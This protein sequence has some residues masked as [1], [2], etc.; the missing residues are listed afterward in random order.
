M[1]IIRFLSPYNDWYIHYSLIVYLC[2]N[3]I[4]VS[5]H[6][7][8]ENPEGDPSNRKLNEYIGFLL[9]VY[10]ALYMP[11]IWSLVTVV[12]LWTGNWF[13]IELVHAVVL[14]VVVR[15]PAPVRG[16]QFESPVRETN[17]EKKINL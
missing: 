11:F 9:I 7:Y 4:F 8:P 6:M 12:A 5:S 10:Q 15:G 14:K 2:F 3:T 16:A 17:F 13:I 1:I